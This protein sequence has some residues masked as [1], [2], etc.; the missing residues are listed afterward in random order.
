MHDSCAADNA[1]EPDIDLVRFEPLM[2]IYGLQFTEVCSFLCI[3]Y[4]L[5]FAPEIT[6]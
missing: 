6:E 5:H 1:L 3:P 2:P 4:R